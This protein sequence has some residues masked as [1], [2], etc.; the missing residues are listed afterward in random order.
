VVGTKGLYPKYEPQETSLI[1]K[2]YVKEVFAYTS[3]Y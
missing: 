3:K 1:L 2:Q